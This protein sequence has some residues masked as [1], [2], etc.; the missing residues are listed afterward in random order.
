MRHLIA[1]T[2]TPARMTAQQRFN[3]HFQHDHTIQWYLDYGLSIVAESERMK[4]SRQR[5]ATYALLLIRTTHTY[6]L[7]PFRVHFICTNTQLLNLCAD[8]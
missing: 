6:A 3:Y 7:T 5:E 4:L 2:Y 1:L 8:L